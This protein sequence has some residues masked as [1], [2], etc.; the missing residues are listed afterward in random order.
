MAIFFYTLDGAFHVIVQSGLAVIFKADKPV[1][2]GNLYFLGL[3]GL[4]SLAVW[5]GGLLAVVYSE[6]APLFANAPGLLHP[7]PYHAVDALPLGVGF[8]AQGDAFAVS[9]GNALHIFVYSCIF[10]F[11]GIADFTQSTMRLDEVP[12]V[13]FI[14]AP[15]LFAVYGVGIANLP[16]P[17]F[18]CW[19]GVLLAILGNARYLPILNVRNC[20]GLTGS[21][22]FIF[23][24]TGFGR[25]DDHLVPF[26]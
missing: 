3:I 2:L 12:F 19:K 5:H 22:V 9:G 7:R 16:S 14:Q 18:V 25:R 26:G 21:G 24:A 20:N 6:G 1:T 15:G 10:H 11:L 13:A 4:V 17:Q 8:Y 23:M